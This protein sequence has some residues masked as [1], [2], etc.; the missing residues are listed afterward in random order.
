[1]LDLFD[2]ANSPS[3]SQLRVASPLPG[4]DDDDE[5]VDGW[6]RKAH[7][8]QWLI[9]ACRAP[10]VGGSLGTISLSCPLGCCVDEAINSSTATVFLGS[11]RGQSGE[12]LATRAAA[13]R[14]MGRF[15]D[16]P[17]QSSGPLE[18]EVH[19]TGK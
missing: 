9:E 12:D 18:S 13:A 14:A 5:R 2:P 8:A 11:L 15:A 16:D 4:N 1:M 6:M 3:S 17:V 10:S 19:L 7:L